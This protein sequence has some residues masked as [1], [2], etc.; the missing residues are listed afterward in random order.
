MSFHYAQQMYTKNTLRK[1]HS[2]PFGH[3]EG[4]NRGPT[5]K[6]IT[7]PIYRNDDY[8]WLRSDDR[9]NQEV[10]NLLQAENDITTH[11]MSDSDATTA[12]LFDEMKSRINAN[13]ST[14]P[15]K[16]YNTH[17]H[18]Y[19][20]YV[21]DKGYPIYCRK[22]Q[23]EPSQEEILLD[24]NALAKNNSACDVKVTTSY[25]GN[26]LSYAVDYEGNEKYQVHFKDLTTSTELPNRINN[27]M[28]ASY[29]W[30]PTNQHIYYVGHDDA[31]RMFRLCIYD[32]ATQESRILYEE[33]DV[34]FDMNL[35]LSNSMRYIFVL[36][37]S[38]DTSEIYVINPL[39]SPTNLT[40]F[41]QR[42]TNML[43]MVED[44]DDDTF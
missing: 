8:Y 5:S 7:P 11:T 44:Y 37:K 42:Q 32:I 24:V 27:L 2:V 13:E 3:I 43:Y 33:L 40:L 23:I 31:N 20:T 22:S 34:L 26:I 29:L 19:K 4:Q 18:Y 38:S 30:S 9:N 28:Y 1:P 15:Y 25:D 21:E 14:Y 16:F 12:Q 35:K 36:I 39:E 6:L 17:Y 10:L 41:K